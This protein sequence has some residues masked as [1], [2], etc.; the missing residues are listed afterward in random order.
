MDIQYDTFVPGG[1]MSV[2]ARCLYEELAGEDPDR[3]YSQMMRF[4]LS[5]HA[6]GECTDTYFIATAAGEYV[7][8]LWHGWGT[9]PDSIGNFGNFKTL[10]KYQRQGI[11]RKLLNLWYE[12]L[13]G[14]SDLPLALF[15]TSSKPHLVRLYGEYGFRPA[16][17][18]AEGGPLYCPLGDSPESFQEFCER[19]YSPAKFLKIR[20]ASVGWR[21]EIDCLL[22]FYLLDHQRNLSLSGAVNLEYALLHPEA[23][24]AELFFT[25][26]G[27]CAGWAFTPVGGK[28]SCCL[29]PG[30]QELPV[31]EEK[32]VGE[33]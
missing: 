12:N 20:P 30:Y 26:A 11:G 25:D 2:P 32:A 7:A 15:C 1:A 9:H 6:A 5:G 3:T 14:R 28:R 27:R 29:Y 10:E 19:Y 22:K 8:R 24:K 4:R 23:G 13:N 31:R 18:G 33:R 17:Q 16:L 21:H